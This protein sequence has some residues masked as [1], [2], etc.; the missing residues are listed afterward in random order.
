[1]KV[2]V[3]IVHISGIDHNQSLFFSLIINFNFQTI[4]VNDWS[5][6]IS[7]LMYSCQNNKFVHFVQDQDAKKINAAN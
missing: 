3:S 2:E 6:S 7:E 4:N 5:G 1:M